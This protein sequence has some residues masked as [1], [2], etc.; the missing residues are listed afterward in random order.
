MRHHRFTILFVFGLLIAQ[1]TK[2]QE[3]FNYFFRH[4][5]Q[6]DGLLHNEVLSIAQD[7]KGFIWVA[8]HNGLQRYDGSRFVYYPEMLS[9]PAEGV[10]ASAGI[11]ADKKNNLLWITNNASLEKME[12]G[13]NH[14]TV[15]DPEKLLNDHSFVFNSF[16][17]INNE[18]WL[19]GQNAV[20][21]YDSAAKI[22]VPYYLN[23]LPQNTHQSSF[24]ADD[25]SGNNRWMVSG[26]QLILFNKKSKQAWSANF[27]AGDHPLL[28]PSFHGQEERLLRFVMIDSRQNIWITTWGDMLYKYNDDTKTISKYSLSTIKTKEDGGKASAAGLLVNCILEDDNHVVWIGTENAGLL[29]Y[30]AAKDNFD[31]CIA[32]EKNGESIRYIYKILTLFQDKE[33]N[34]WIGTDRGISIFNPYRQYFSSVKHEESN[35]LSM[36]KNEIDCFIQTTAGDIFIG[37]WGGGMTQYDNQFHFKKNIFLKG[38]HQNNFIWCF[39]QVD[40][41]T[42]WIGCQHGYLQVYDIASGSI[43]TLLPPEMERSTIRCME[44]D[45]RGNIWFGLHNGKIVKWDKQ[46]QKFFPSRDSLKAMATVLN[47][48]IDRSQN[49]WVSTEAGF[50]QFDPEKM[51]YSTTWLPDKKNPTSISGKTCQGIEE[52]NDSVLLIGTIYG[53][54]NFF[55]KRTKTF[56]HLNTADGLPSNTIYAIKKDKEHHVWFT[57]DYGLYKFDPAEKKFIPYSMEPGI[58]NSSFIAYKFYPLHDGRWLTFTTS[59]AVSFFPGKATYQDMHQPTRIEITGF[60]LFNKPVFI[61][62]LLFENKPVQLSHKENFFTIEF[63]ALNFSSLQQINYYYRLGGVDKEWVNGGTKRFA[64]YTDLQPGE[65]TFEVKTEN[66]NSTEE[67]TSFKIIITPPFWQTWW[68]IS[69][70]M[71]LIVLS[72]FWLFRR[73]INTIRHDAQMKQTIAETEMMALRTQMNPHFIF[74]CLNSID[75]LIQTDQKEKATD[76]LAKFAQLIRSILENSKNNTIPCWKDLE[77]LQLY[78]QM[79]ELRWDKKITC[80]VTIADEIQNGDYKVPPMIVQPF[81]ENAIHHGLL[82]KV[83]PDKKLSIDVKLE[84]NKIKYTVTDN[85]I[86]RQKGD[87]YKKLNRSS[88]VSFGMQI[89]KDRI[90]LFNQHTNGSVKVTDLYN[91][92]QQPAGTIVEVWLSTQPITT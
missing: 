81:V 51:I 14:F 54:L 2:A 53:G 33:Q 66:A 76:Y 12:T 38:P 29:R 62:S 47:I 19:V 43:Q 58:I 41:K 84:E 21:R 36:P 60:K 18:Q 10:R 89:T 52:Y 45:S 56:S 22:N 44:K 40:D 31:Y 24:I 88:Q 49:C 15:Y 67:I 13:K 68:F 90:N 65:Y 70:C 79:E 32:Q 23:I 73:R 57:T 85:G 86:G 75:N 3:S 20:Y 82:N 34:I 16:K 74:N 5:D 55:N 39:Q 87:E 25:S 11:Y 28:Q 30:S 80:N 61:D 77:T 1:G 59:E 91:E 27:N 4:I 83:D 50:K 78:L 37:T 8:T 71:A 92:L 7:G 35:S 9:N 63:A 17:G 64:N 26:S 72:V 69:T 42:L 48:L 6:A 46:L